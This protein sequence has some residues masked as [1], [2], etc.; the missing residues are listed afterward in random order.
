MAPRRT[1]MTFVVPP[2]SFRLYSFVAMSP[3]DKILHRFQWP[4]SSPRRL[5][6]VCCADP[7]AAT[8]RGV[9]GRHPARANTMIPSLC[10]GNTT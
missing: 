4:S 2:T 3:D 1:V 5:P 9:G 7:R 6:A 8:F 10:Q